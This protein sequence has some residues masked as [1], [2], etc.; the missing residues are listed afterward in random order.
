MVDIYCL[1]LTNGGVINISSIKS[2]LCLYPLYSF[3]VCYRENYRENDIKRR[4][5]FKK[6]VDGSNETSAIK[7]ANRIIHTLKKF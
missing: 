2:R 4:K 7:E 5:I 6:L 1:F 3:F